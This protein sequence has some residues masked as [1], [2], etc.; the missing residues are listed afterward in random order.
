[1][2]GANPCG[3][4]GCEELIRCVRLVDDNL[5][6]WCG[7]GVAWRNLVG[8]G[9][10]VGRSMVWV[11]SGS[12]PRVPI[13]QLWTFF[14]STRTILKST[15]GSQNF[16]YFT[17]RFCCVMLPQA[18][19]LRWGFPSQEGRATFNRWPRARRHRTTGQRP[20]SR[21][22]SRHRA[23]RTHLGHTRHLFPNLLHSVA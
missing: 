12:R 14:K 16:L 11:P 20:P 8:R 17:F 4:I 9:R 7:R 23:A 2:R 21:T 22:R 6:C 3:Q 1:M 19:R 5:G 13:P 15:L 18:L 10:S